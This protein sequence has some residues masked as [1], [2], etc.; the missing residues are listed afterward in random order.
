MGRMRGGH[1]SACATMA[2][3]L[4]VC[5]ITLFSPPSLSLSLH[6]LV[7]NNMPRPTCLSGIGSS[8]PAA[9]KRVSVPVSILNPSTRRYWPPASGHRSTYVPHAH[10]P[11]PPP[12]FSIVCRFMGDMSRP[13]QMP[14]T[15]QRSQFLGPV[16]VPRAHSEYKGRD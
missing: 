8:H 14:T 3:A 2:L 7:N 4:R 13:T 11:P 15:P 12:Q 6:G 16:I 5:S 10:S 1:P 9:I